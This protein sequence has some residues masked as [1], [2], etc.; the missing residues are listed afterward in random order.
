MAQ[1]GIKTSRFQQHLKKNENVSRFQLSL[2]MACDS[3]TE[4]AR[5]KRNE[6]PKPCKIFARKSEVPWKGLSVEVCKLFAQI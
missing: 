1:S 4:K 2:I 3:I 5:S 6:K